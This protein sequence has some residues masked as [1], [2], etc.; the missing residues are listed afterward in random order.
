VPLNDD[1]KNKQAKREKFKM[2]S[3]K[4]KSLGSSL[5]ETGLIFDAYL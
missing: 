4:V 2:F 5:G 3:V 1:E